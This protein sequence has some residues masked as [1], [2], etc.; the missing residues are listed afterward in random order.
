MDDVAADT[1]IR[2]TVIEAIEAD[3]F[4]LCGGTVYAR[5]H[6]RSI[7][8]VV[9]VDSEPLIARVR[10][11]SP[12][13]ARPVAAVV[14]QPTDRPGVGR[15]LRATHSPNWTVAMVAAL[16]LICGLAL[17]GLLAN[18]SGGSNTPSIARRQRSRIIPASS[19]TAA[20]PSSPPPS[21]VA[22]LPAQR[23]RPCWCGR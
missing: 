8:R 5:G 19:S 9:G 15:P 14:A 18:Q 10:R 23:A 16:V 3:H 13:G 7:A 17:A 11:R 4:E 21:S 22:E 20:A 2:A 6:I 1:R 12:R